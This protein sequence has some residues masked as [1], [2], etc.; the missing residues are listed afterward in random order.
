MIFNDLVIY[1][2]IYIPIKNDKKML[3][4]IAMLDYQRVHLPSGTPII[5]LPPFGKNER[6]ENHHSPTGGCYPYVSRPLSRYK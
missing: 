2:Y 5:V 6:A 3:F 1:I 4:S